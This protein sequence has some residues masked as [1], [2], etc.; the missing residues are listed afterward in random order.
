MPFGLSKN[1]QYLEFLLLI[2]LN[3]SLSYIGPGRPPFAPVTLFD[4][5]VAFSISSLPFVCWYLPFL[6]TFCYVPFR[7]LF[8]LCN[9]PLFTLDYLQGMVFKPLELLALN[10]AFCAGHF[11]LLH[12]YL[13]YS[14]IVL[15]KSRRRHLYLSTYQATLWTHIKPSVGLI[16]SCQKSG[17]LAAGRDRSMGMVRRRIICP[18]MSFIL[19]LP[20]GPGC[21]SSIIILR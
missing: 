11:R 5:V 20:P 17:F 10:G 18:L 14:R 8:I 4:G 1:C 7:I 12:E 2:T 3:R 15:D 19:R 9:Q 21:S 16:C 13:P 6:T